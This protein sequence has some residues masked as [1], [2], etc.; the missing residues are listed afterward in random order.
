MEAGGADLRL[1]MG[2]AGVTECL[3]HGLDTVQV[4]GLSAQL[5]M[6]RPRLAER[7]ASL[8]ARSAGW[9]HSCLCRRRTQH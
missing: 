9:R 5:K 1:L 3:G 8:V 6:Y 7:Y 2:Q 4:A